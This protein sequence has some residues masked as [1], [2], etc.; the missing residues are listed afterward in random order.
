MR[1]SDWSSDVCSSDLP[2]EPGAGIQRA[3]ITIGGAAQPGGEPDEDDDTIKPL[4]ERLMTELT[5]HRTLALRSAV[6]ADPDTAYL[7]VLHALA[8]KTFYRFSTATCLEIEA[9]HSAFGHQEIGR[10]HV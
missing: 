6:G 10:A 8:L 3:V 2:S 4:P 5:A 7:A 9:K 1:I